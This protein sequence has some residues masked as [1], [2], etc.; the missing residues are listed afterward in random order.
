MAKKPLHKPG[1]AGRTTFP[2]THYSSAE[3]PTFIS[4]QLGTFSCAMNESWMT[5]NSQFRQMTNEKVC[6]MW[7][8][9]CP[10]RQWHRKVLKKV[11]IFFDLTNLKYSGPVQFVFF[12]IPQTY[13]T[14][15]ATCK[16]DV[17]RGV[18]G[19]TPHFIHM[20]LDKTVN[21]TQI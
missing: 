1:S 18:C 8:P 11:K 10:S 20:P 14:I 15:I 17:L 9:S 6:V 19:Q 5:M 7:H 13:L 12:C 4:L 16:K 2:I 3:Q 21:N